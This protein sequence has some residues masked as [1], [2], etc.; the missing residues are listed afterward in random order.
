MPPRS[1]QTPPPLPPFRDTH[2]PPHAPR[3]PASFSRR[4]LFLLRPSAATASITLALAALHADVE[5]IQNHLRIVETAL[6]NANSA[7]V[8]PPPPHLQA[9]PEEELPLMPPLTPPLPRDFIVLSDSES[10]SESDPIEFSDDDDANDSDDSAELALSAPVRD[11]IEDDD[12]TRA[13]CDSQHCG[14]H[15]ASE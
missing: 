1:P 15:S 6:A 2:Q 11:Q 13:T 4:R 8:S 3:K 5:R 12:E 14:D 10:E 7:I 9:L